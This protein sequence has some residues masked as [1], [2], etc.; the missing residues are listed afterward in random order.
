MELKWGSK[1]KHIDLINK[2]FER[3]LVVRYIGSNKHR[4]S[5]WLCKCDCGNEVV[6]SRTNLKSGNTKSCGCYKLEKVKRK[7]TTHGMTKTRFYIIFMDILARCTNENEPAYKNYGARGIKCLWS[8]FENFKED[9]Y[10]SYLQHCK[11]F[12]EKN[13]TIDRIDNNDNYCKEN[14]RWA[15]QK[16]QQNN[17]RRSR[18]VKIDGEQLTISQAAEK[19]G[20][21]YKTIIYRI[22]DGKDIF[23]RRMN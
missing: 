21:N 15:T 16:E 4:Q 10:E 2:R 13:T 20:I 23:G 1:L 5:L 8:S 11:E 6:V 22:N 17:T 18:Y 12:G 19:Y 3:L 9:M 14:C 7:L